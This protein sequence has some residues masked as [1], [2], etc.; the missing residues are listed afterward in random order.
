VGQY[1]AV[2][3]GG[4]GFLSVFS[5]NGQI[6]AV[7]ADAG[8]TPLD[9]SWLLL[10]DA[11]TNG[12]YYPDLAY[13]GNNYLVTW[14]DSSTDTIQGRVVNPDGT[15]AGTAPLTITT[16]NSTNAS[17]AWDGS[18]FVAVWNVY[19]T[20]STTVQLAYFDSTGTL[21]AGSEKTVVSGGS[22]YE[23]KVVASGSQLFV[24]WYNHSTSNAYSTM[25]GTRVDSSGNVLDTVPLQLGAGASASVSESGLELAT[26]GT[27]FLA[28]W[29]RQRTSGFG[30]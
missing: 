19:N 29:M 4:S 21:V 26:D 23:P 27:N 2:A 14:W 18:R 22:F 8:G 20:G 1:P 15:V 17:V 25:S 5:D 28:T 13:N 24:G 3:N 9:V 30:V 16:A 10:S 11:S 7:R 12:S 6:R